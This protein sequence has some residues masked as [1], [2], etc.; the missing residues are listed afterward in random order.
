MKNIFNNSLLIL[1]FAGIFSCK[2]DSTDYLDGTQALSPVYHVS[3][4]DHKTG[5]QITGL[6]VALKDYNPVNPWADYYNR[7]YYSTG[8]VA[9]KNDA[10]GS[11]IFSP[12]TRY[13]TFNSQHY[14]DALYYVNDQTDPITHPVHTQEGSG[15]PNVV[16]AK[17]LR[18]EGNHFYFR[19]DLYRKAPVDI[20]IR[21]V[22]DYSDTLNAFFNA[23][24]IGSDPSNTAN[25]F[26]INDL[27]GSG[28]QLRPD[29]KIDTTI[30]IYGF[31]D[32]L[33]KVSWSAYRIVDNGFVVIG[34]K[35]ISTGDMPEKI[36][37][38]DT[39]TSI[40]ITF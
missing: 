18:N 5:E 19:A 14:V 2:K 31:G 4:Y 23:S 25:N 22:S 38:S 13:L 30:S 29:K 7:S 37:P 17:L 3:F 32:Y 11:I 1:L 39:P 36:L 20:H 8:S 16:Y 27:W 26:G 34:K 40:T 35:F 6:E 12:G 21:Q 9:L 28:L 10:N 15:G 33:N 24:I